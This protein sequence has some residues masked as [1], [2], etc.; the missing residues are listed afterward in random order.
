KRSIVCNDLASLIWLA[1]HS[2]IE[3]HVPFQ[4]VSS[5]FPNEIVFDLDPPHR[6]KFHV[7]VVAAQMIKT[8]L[9]ELALEGF[10][11]TSGN[12]GLQIHVPLPHNK[13]SY[14]ETAVLTEAIAKTLVQ[15]KPSLFTTERMKKNR[16][17]ELYIDYVQHGENKTIIAPYSPRKTEEA[18]IATPLFW[19]EVNNSLRPEQFTIQH[20]VKRVQTLGCHWLFYDEVRRGQDVSKMMTLIDT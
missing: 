20:V 17:G 15:T 14:E 11:K 5:A 8:L 7:A 9:E 12:K 1:N 13:V 4:T 18:T 10:V 16:E 6:E 19:H 3:Y 2:A